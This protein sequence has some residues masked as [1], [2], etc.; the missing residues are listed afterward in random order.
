MFVVRLTERHHRAASWASVRRC[1]SLDHSSHHIRL[2]S[3]GMKR[4]LMT[5]IVVSPS[6]A[7]TTA[8]DPATLSGGPPVTG[9]ALLTDATF[10]HATYRRGEGSYREYGFGVVARF[11]NRTSAPVDLGRCL[12]DSPTPIHGVVLAGADDAG[13]DGTGS[14][15]SGAWACVGHDQP[16]VVQ[17]GQT[18]VDTL[19]IIGPNSFDGRTGQPFGTLVGR[20]RLVYDVRACRGDGPCEADA[21]M[22]R[23][24]EFEVRLAP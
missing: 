3:R 22:G 6:L 19:Q 15:Y 18:R 7:C 1:P 11:T 21:E 10:Y 16:F 5:G 13:S 2:R 4:L 24:N 20:M 17:P 8:T 14:A 23:S 9:E 12:P